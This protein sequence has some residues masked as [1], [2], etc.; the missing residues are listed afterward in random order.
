MHASI[1]PF[2]LALALLFAA[3]CVAVPETHAEPKANLT[4][5]ADEALLLPLSQL[6]RDYAK[7]TGTP[8][9]VVLNNAA[10]TEHQIEQG[11]EAHALITANRALMDRLTEQGLTD[12]SSRHAVA[13]TQLAL[14][15]ANGLSKQANLAK[16]I[17]FATM[18][19][20][21]PDLPIFA[22]SADTLDGARITPLL[23]GHEFSATLASRLER[24]PNREEV[25]EALRDGEGLAIV[26]ASDAATERDL[27]VLALLPEEISPAATYEAVVLGSEAMNEAKAFTTFL[28]SREAQATLAHFGFQGARN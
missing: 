10:T 11:L 13:R 17:S 3:P 12:V 8:L 4:I 21:T 5:L 25:L 20:A 6:A 22:V 16:R 24:K 15:S 7:A 19:Y 23:A 26:F 28:N 14:I 9:T 1:K 27:N 2:T 18:L